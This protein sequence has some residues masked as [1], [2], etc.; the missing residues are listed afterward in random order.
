MLHRLRILGGGGEV[1]GRQGDQDFLQ[2]LARFDHAPQMGRGDFQTP[3]IGQGVA[4]FAAERQKV[5]M[6]QRQY[7]FLAFLT[8][9]PDHKLDVHGV[10]VT[11]GDSS[12]QPSK[13]DLP[14]P[15]E[16]VGTSFKATRIIG[17]LLSDYQMMPPSSLGPA[18]S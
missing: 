18:P 5:G 17:H 13:L 1:C 15:P 2:V 12:L 11:D 14:N 9:R 4:G 6:P 10:G 7:A 3:G 8:V 16:G